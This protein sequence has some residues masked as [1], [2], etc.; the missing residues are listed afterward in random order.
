M[1][2]LKA[3]FLEHAEHFKGYTLSEKCDMAVAAGFDRAVVSQYAT[4][5]RFHEAA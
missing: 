4:Q 5:M 3:W 2:E 1:N